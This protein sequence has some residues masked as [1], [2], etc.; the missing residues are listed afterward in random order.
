MAVNPDIQA[1]IN[2]KIT[3]PMF[4]FSDA[5]Q[6]LAKENAIEVGSI[7]SL[8]GSG[9]NLSSDITLLSSSV[10]RLKAQASHWENAGASEYIYDMICNRYKLPF[11]QIPEAV[12]LRNN[13]SALDNLDFVS[14]FADK[15]MYIGGNLHSTG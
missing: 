5:Q 11:R 4:S 3:I 10:G 12:I 13:K 2:A 6:E 8:Q 14:S 15:T 7:Q 1:D 9:K